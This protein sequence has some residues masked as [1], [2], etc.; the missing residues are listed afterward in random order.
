[1]KNNGMPKITGVAKKVS[2]LEEL[3]RL[4]GQADGLIS[5]AS[6]LKENLRPI[7][8]SETSEVD[9]AH[10]RNPPTSSVLDCIHLIREKLETA[11][12]IHTNTINTLQI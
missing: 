10:D 1:M 3:E 2:I 5:Q 9:P 8:E 11:S 6:L 7:L 4:S 12:N